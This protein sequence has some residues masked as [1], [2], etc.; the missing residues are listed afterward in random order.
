MPSSGLIARS[1]LKVKGNKV[2][3]R[4]LRRRGS[5]GFLLA[6]ILDAAS[7]L[8]QLSTEDHLTEPGFWPTQSS[9]SRDNF[10]GSGACARC[11][12]SKAAAQKKTPMARAAMSASLSDILH[13]NPLMVFGPGKYRY[14]IE[15][16]ASQ[17]LYSVSAGSESLSFPL[18]WAFG[19]GRVGQSYL[20][21]KQ[22]ASFFEAR[23]HSHSFHLPAPSVIVM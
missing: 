2:L 12:R 3:L 6:V 14:R 10:T 8:G 17:S 13:A 20:F 15:T 21:E 1:I 11:H 5:L 4:Y 23:C 16:G 7:A 22:D 9:P 19:T 18:L